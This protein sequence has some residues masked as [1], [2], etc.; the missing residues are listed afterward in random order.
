MTS[1]HRPARQTGFAAVAAIFL[2]VALAALGSFMVSISN[3]QQLTA[4]QDVQGIRAY[5]AARAAMEWLVGKTKAA[6][7]CP[8]ASSSFTL[9]GFDL[10]ASCS[11]ATFSE[12]AAS[13]KVFSLG[14][15]ASSGTAGKTGYVERSL[16][17]G[18]EM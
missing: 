10:V 12:G 3:T 9:E 4:A 7:A 8:A 5:W 15:Q 13:V 2:V 6:S 14:V 11:M 1:L 16:S 17:A 18:L